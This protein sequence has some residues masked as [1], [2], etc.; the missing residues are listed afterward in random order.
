MR[1]LVTVSLLLG[2]AVMSGHQLK[3]T[4]NLGRLFHCR[5]SGRRGVPPL[6]RLELVPLARAKVVLVTPFDDIVSERHAGFIRE[7][8]VDAKENATIDDL[9]YG[10]R[11][12]R[13][14][15]CVLN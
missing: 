12:A 5:H 15:P 4:S 3:C 10:L 2:A 9:L 11:K 1:V 13:V 8:E 14:I 7:P 6:I